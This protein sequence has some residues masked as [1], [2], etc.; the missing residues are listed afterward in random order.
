MIENTKKRWVTY[1]AL[2]LEHGKQAE[3]FKSKGVSYSEI[4]RTGIRACEKHFNKGAENGK[5][6]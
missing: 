4:F 5:N 2:S 1:I 6:V 3:K